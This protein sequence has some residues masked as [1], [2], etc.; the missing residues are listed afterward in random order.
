MSIDTDGHYTWVV[1]ED[2]LP[3]A[4]QLTNDLIDKLR[5]LVTPLVG[6]PAAGTNGTKIGVV[7]VLAIGLLAV[8]AI[9]IFR[10]K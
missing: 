2:K 6:T 3:P 1:V 9:L 5:S 7:T 8:G 4:R 10:R